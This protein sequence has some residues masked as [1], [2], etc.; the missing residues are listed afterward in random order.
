MPARLAQTLAS[1]LNQAIEGFIANEREQAQML[2]VQAS[3]LNTWANQPT[4]TSTARTV[5]GV[6]QDS[7]LRASIL[8]IVARTKGADAAKSL[9]DRL[10]KADAAINSISGLV[11][12]A[13][14]TP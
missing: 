4:I 12:R 5:A 3:A 7:Q 11:Q 10:S 14:S 8:E 6:F 1:D 2:G 13:T 9:S